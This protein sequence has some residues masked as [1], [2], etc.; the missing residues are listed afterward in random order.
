MEDNDNQ[1]EDFLEELAR[2]V[3][4]LRESRNL[5]Q[6]D[7]YN[8]TGIHFGRI[9]TGR[10]DPK[11]STIQRISNYFDLSVAEFFAEGFGE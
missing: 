9:E 11:M 7:A 5:T 4:L 3:K 2:R 10:W 1:N 6:E 8:D